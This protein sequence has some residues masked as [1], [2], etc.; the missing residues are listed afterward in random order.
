MKHHPTF[1]KFMD[2]ITADLNNK[3]LNDIE[4]GDQT[5]KSAPKCQS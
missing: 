2:A 5:P 1:C 3:K 4:A